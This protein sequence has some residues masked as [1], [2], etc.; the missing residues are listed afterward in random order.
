MREE[1]T[2]S[3]ID[4]SINEMKLNEK[5]EKRKEKKKQAKCLRTAKILIIINNWIINTDKQHGEKIRENGMKN[6]EEDV[7]S[8]K[9]VICFSATLIDRMDGRIKE[10]KKIAKREQKTDTDS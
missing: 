4:Q 9:S 3:K 2:G 5:I 10:K 1:K 6:G 7:W 8:K